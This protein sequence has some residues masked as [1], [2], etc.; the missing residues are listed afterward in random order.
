MGKLKLEIKKMNCYIL[1]IGNEIKETHI[2]DDFK[3]LNITFIKPVLKIHKRQSGATG[4]MRIIEM[5]T[6][7]NQTNNFKPFIILEDDVSKMGEM[8]EYIE[9]P[10]NIDLLYIGVSKAGMAKDTHCYQVYTSAVNGFSHLLRV[11]NMCST[12]G[13][14]VC[15]ILG[16]LLIQKCVTEDYFNKRGWDISLTQSQ[17]YYNVYALKEPL[18]YQDK[19]YGGQEDNTKIFLTN[20]YKAENM[21]LEYFNKTNYSVMTTIDMKNKDKIIYEFPKE[22]INI[23]KKRFS[24]F[25]IIILSYLLIIISKRLIKKVMF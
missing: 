16:C 18:V 2:Q 8:P 9:V 23:K 19:L 25:F 17:P 4:F 22:N 20:S 21:P 14:I 1:S 24:S 12:H 6:K 11:Y 15:S 3:G 10:N 5:A 13:I 7:E